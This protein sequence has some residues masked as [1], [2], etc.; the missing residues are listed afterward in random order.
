MLQAK[1]YKE[2][3]FQMYIFFETKFSIKLSEKKKKKRS[4]KFCSK[5]KFNISKLSYEI[6]NNFPLKNESEGRLKNIINIL[7]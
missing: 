4:N 2:T 1:I 7:I 5:Y 3:R 6:P